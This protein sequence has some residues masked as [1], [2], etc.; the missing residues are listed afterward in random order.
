[1]VDVFLGDMV[2]QLHQMI[3]LESSLYQFVKDRDGIGTKSW[4]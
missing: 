3:K 2:Q 4:H 1:M